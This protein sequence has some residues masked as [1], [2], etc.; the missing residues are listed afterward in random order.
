MPVQ[1][2]ARR[3]VPVTP[4]P[5]NAIECRGATWR[6]L[7]ESEGFWE[8]ELIK[9]GANFAEVPVRAWALPALEAEGIRIVDEED[10][11][12]AFPTEAQIAESKLLKPTLAAHRNRV[13]H[14]DENARE[15][16]TASQCAIDHKPWQFEPWRRIVET[17]PFPRLLIADDVGLGKTTEAAIILAELA[18]RRRADR[19]MIVA[20]QHLCEKW[21]DELFN[22]FGLVFE[23]F[24]RETRE[25]LSDRGVTNPW[26]VVERVIVSRDFVK[27]WEN[28]KPLSHVSWDMV[29]IDECHHFV[30]DDSGFS[31]RLRDFAEKI[32]LRSPGLLLL[33]ATPF[34]GSK[35]EF[36]SLLGLL[37]PK[38]NGKDAEWKSSNPY[39]IRRLKK[40][41]RSSGENFKD[42]ELFTIRISDSD[43]S[44]DERKC[45]EVVNEIL[46]NQTKNASGAENWRHLQVETLR[47]RLSS[48]W[49]AFY[50]TCTSG[51]ISKWFDQ[52]AAKKIEA[53]INKG[54]TA[55]LKSV[56]QSLKD[57]H[58]KDPAK[59]I[60][61]FTEAIASQ[62]AL[63]EYL[64]RKG[65]S[66]EQVR[67]I[68]GQTAR[69]ER[70][71]LEDDF[72]NP[73]SNLRIL[74]ATD[75]IAE[76][77]DLQHACHHLMH[78]ELPWSLVKIEQ[79]NGRIDRLGQR[80]SPK[81]YNVILDLS[82]TPDQRILDR[83]ASRMN[84]AQ[85][86]LGSISPILESDQMRFKDIV[87]SDS[88]ID[89]VINVG[90]IKKQYEDL[91][92][93]ESFLTP[94]AATPVSHRDDS[95]ERRAFLDLMITRLGGALEPNGK[96]SAEELLYLPEERW[97]LPELLT[98]LFGYPTKERP[99][100][101]TFSPS[102]YLRYEKHLL[103]GGLVT[104]PLQ[105][106]SPIHPVVQ[107]TESRFRF[108]TGRKGYPI[109][110]V[111]NAPALSTAV[112]E[113]TLRSPK[114]RVILQ[115]LEFIDVKTGEQLDP[116][117]FGDLVAGPQKAKIPGKDQWS[118]LATKMNNRLGNLSKGVVG[119]FSK[120]KTELLKEH[121]AID[122][123]IL[124]LESRKEW[125]EELWT[126]ES[127]QSQFQVLGLIVAGG[128]A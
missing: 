21:Q 48:S 94:L 66:G 127:S 89:D 52:S 7:R 8:L 116:S 93:D 108:L 4:K 6:F 123:A 115:S 100:R 18:R 112:V 24:T 124:G 110:A 9:Q 33:S 117:A 78:F 85:Q 71:K 75:T 5:G 63:K 46:E 42:R 61:I 95:A 29:V 38:F 51:E 84:E 86:S 12:C 118:G 11:F 98:D 14:V 3:A 28:F 64:L 104:T 20:P 43:L 103:S 53:L 109:F 74:I 59:K 67:T 70:L 121:Q 91:G 73:N 55:K 126:V 128:V 57:I 27:R 72:A 10:S 122:P 32:A 36:R 19:V 114:G 62:V 1:T 92:L 2:P 41:V 69:E 22:R 23:I 107:F 15:A 17:L 79:R 56:G 58:K 90:A 97:P 47:K 76:G 34:T 25:R 80:E 49:H 88:K 77:K 102:H 105:F 113:F 37:D 35:E 119:Q 45:F 31:T 87:E 83:L 60:V 111:K 44:K 40:D 39:M 106:L 65:Y 50:E 101:V 120:R 68:E 96:N 54:E 81:V 26:D 125:I 13:I 16:T 99:W 82:Y 30:R